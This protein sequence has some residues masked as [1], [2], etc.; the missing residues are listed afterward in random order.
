MPPIL[1]TAVLPHDVALSAPEPSKKS[2]PNITWEGKHTD[3]LVEWSMTH[4]AD[5]HILFHDC[6]TSTSASKPPP[7][8]KPSGKSK[9]EVSAAIA[10]HIFITDPD[11]SFLYASDPLRYVTSVINQL[12]A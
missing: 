1:P 11:H 6:V 5:W 9:K 4:T 8:D 3:Q 2:M 7:G 12:G 10:R